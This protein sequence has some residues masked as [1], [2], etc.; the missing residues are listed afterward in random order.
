[1][2]RRDAERILRVMDQLSTQRYVPAGLRV[3]V[4]AGLGDRELTFEWLEKG[5][6]NREAL[7]FVNSDLRF[8]FLRADP[9]FPQVLRRLG[10]S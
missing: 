9:R 3:V 2:A 1:V 5:L 7:G 4:C 8:E 6:A 10:L